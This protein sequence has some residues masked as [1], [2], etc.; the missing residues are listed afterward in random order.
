V[1]IEIDSGM[2]RGGAQ[3][4]EA[5]VA[6]AKQ[7]VTMP[8]LRFAG[9]M[10]WEG[11]AMAIP[12][13]E[14]RRAAI[15]EAIELVTTTADAIRAEGIPVDIVSCGGTGT[16]TTARGAK[17]VSELQ[18]GGGIFGDAVYRGLEVPVKPALTVQVTVTS[19]PNPSTILIDAGRKTVDPSA[20][21]PEVMGID[22]VQSTGWSA[23]HGTIRLSEP[24][25]TPRVGDRL[26]LQ[27]GYSDQAVH[28]HEQFYVQRKG[29]IVAVWPTLA[30]GKLT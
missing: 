24:S 27:V 8:N 12:D 16:L 25:D 1:V 17:G 26:T 21:A 4:G 30:R 2:K 19:R 7:L 6:L 15:L 20:M 5:T 22:N 3:P 23:E 29:T 10:A 14:A 11:H 13:A 18:A 9:V 28:L